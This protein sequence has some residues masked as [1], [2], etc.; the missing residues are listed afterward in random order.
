MFMLFT[1]AEIFDARPPSTLV[2]AIGVALLLPSILLAGC[3]SKP[4]APPPPP[5][6]AAAPQPHALSIALQ[7]SEDANPD[8]RQRPSPVVV[9]VYALRNLAQFDSLDYLALADKDQAVLAADIVTRDELT[10]QPGASHS[11]RRKL[12]PD[13]R[14]VAVT[15]AFRDLERAVWRSA[16]GL[17]PSADQTVQ[18]LVSGRRV[19]VSQR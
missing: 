19:E 4:V 13:S 15:V 9:R 18:V 1:A 12:D 10:L 2:L 3:G 11:I 14:F 5:P 17:A 16:V 8:A 7:V 6:A